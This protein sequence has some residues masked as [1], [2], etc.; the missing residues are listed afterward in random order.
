MQPLLH[1]L[2]Q[3]LLQSFIFWCFLEDNVSLFRALSTHRSQ[4]IE[5]QWQWAHKNG[6]RRFVP[7]LKYTKYVTVSEAKPGGVSAIRKITVETKNI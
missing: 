7:R 5:E 3:K 4:T 2:H 6:K 1:K